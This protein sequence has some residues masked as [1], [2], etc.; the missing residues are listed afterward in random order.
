MR[1]PKTGGTT[2]ARV[3]ESV[4]GEAVANIKNHLPI[5]LRCPPQSYRYITVLRDPCERVW[6]HYQM[7]KRRGAGDPY[8]IY[9]DRG[10]EHFLKCC[11]E[12]QNMM[13]GYLIGRPHRR[14]PKSCIRQA[15]RNLDAFFFVGD[16]N[17]LESD[18][19]R[20]LTA[21]GYAG[22]EI[23]IPHENRG[24]K[25]ALPAAQRELIARYNA[26]DLDL[27]DHSILRRQRNG[28]YWERTI[29]DSISLAR[30]EPD[31]HARRD[32]AL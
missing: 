26:L 12:S 25:E 1:I 18:L 24:E 13:T 20:L 22:N 32:R 6:S 5:S 14:L 2:L 29:E 19:R 31:R 4:A 9:A 27:Y 8:H 10:L 3:L 7:V 15:K 11:W 23:A 28:G 21:L 16:F 30:F 17:D